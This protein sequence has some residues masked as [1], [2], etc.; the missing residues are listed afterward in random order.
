MDLPAAPPTPDSPSAL[1]CAVY[2]RTS[3]ED[4]SEQPY[5]SLDAQREAAL[6]YMASQRGQ[7]WQPVDQAYNDASISGATLDRP[8]L[9]R[10]LAD[11]D[12]GR[13]DVVV[14]HKLD[15]LTRSMADFSLLMTLFDRHQVALVSVT[16]HL[17]SIDATGRLAINTLMSFA[18]FERELIG[19]RIRDKLVATRRKGLWSGSVPPM[20][21]DVRAQHLVVNAVEAQVVREIFQ[22][23]IELSS[24]S[25]LIKELNERSVLTKAWLTKAGKARG[26]RPIDKNYLYKLLRNRM[27]IGELHYDDAWHPGI[28]D[29]IISMETWD[30]AQELLDG[31]QRPGK[32]RPAAA[33]DFLL[34][35]L[36]FGED[37]R[38]YS[39]W[40]SSIRNGRRYRYYVHQCDIAVGAGASGLPRIPVGELEPVV[41]DELR[42]QLRNPQA[43]VEQLSTELKQE[44]AYDQAAALSALGALDEI[45]DLLFYPA[46]REIVAETLDS[47]IVKPGGIEIRFDMA[48]VARVILGVTKAE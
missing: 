32:R 21:Y 20:G 14:V 17:N 3:R 27:L 16:Q 37:G 43:L 10:L 13:I 39:P 42:K 4:E 31:R 11:I 2:T 30:R 22:R 12:A 33:S 34:K 29:S 19:E 35:G 23:F 5:G 24:I 47:V 44:S 26:G 38:A 36:V 9:Q 41:V 1:R 28:H 45:W 46:Q 40:S 25:L 8:A 48:G 15:R 18:Q 6:A 7:N